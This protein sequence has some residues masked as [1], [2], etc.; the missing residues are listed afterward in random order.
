MKSIEKERRL[1]LEGEDTTLGLGLVTDVRVLLAHA[2]HDT[3]MSGSTDDGGEN[4][5]GSVITG[6]TGLAHTGSVI[7]N[8]GNS[9]V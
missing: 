4:S 1:T 3:L 6:E 2:D 5:S 8:E 7:D 9:F